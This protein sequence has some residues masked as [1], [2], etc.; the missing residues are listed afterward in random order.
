MAIKVMQKQIKYVIITPV[1]NEEEHIEKTINSVILQTIT[2]REWIMVNDGSSDNTAKIIDLYSKRYQWIHAIHRKD[3]GFRKAGDG[4]I[5]AFYEGYNS[6]RS[7]NWDY[8]VKLD[9][10]LSFHRDYFES[11]FQ[12]FETNPQL[13]IGGGEIY[14]IDNGVMKREKNPLFHVRGATKIYKK[15]CWDDIGGLIIAPGWDT[16]DEVKANM[17]GWK[18]KSFENIKVIQHRF[19]GSVEGFWK[20]AIKDGMADYI[21]GYHPVFLFFKCIKRVPQK[22][23]CLRSFGLLL[24]YLKGYTKKIPRVDDTAV[25]QYLRKQQMKKIFLKKTIWK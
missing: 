18:T 8:I 23:Y 13:G 16:V 22:P 9:G 11:C 20:T 10:D 5:E 14:H 1:R 17:L 25:I 7:T 19:T 3:R 21:S 12:K 4:V 24:G 15:K 6:V 2:P